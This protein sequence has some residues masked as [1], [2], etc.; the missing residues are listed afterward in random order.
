MPR[1]YWPPAPE[2]RRTEQEA[3]LGTFGIK[4]GDILD[5]ACCYCITRLMRSLLSL[6]IF[7]ALTAVCFAPTMRA[8]T[9]GDILRDTENSSWNWAEYLPV[10]QRFPVPAQTDP[11]V[12]FPPDALMSDFT[13]EWYSGHLAAAGETSLFAQGCDAEA[14]IRFTWLRSFHPPITIRVELHQHSPSILYFKQL[15]VVRGLKHGE[16]TVSAS[17]DLSARS[18]SGLQEMMTEILENPDYNEASCNC[19]TDGARWIVE[20]RT[21]G[22]YTLADQWSPS[23]GDIRTLGLALLDLSDFEGARRRPI[24]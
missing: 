24:Y 18:T 14:C 20:Y 7:L 21:S 15:S 6:G 1:P 10:L 13:R 11:N 12:Y 23:K 8:Q 9:L 4:P 5:A 2:P 17:R 19:G 3:E 22:A 16:P